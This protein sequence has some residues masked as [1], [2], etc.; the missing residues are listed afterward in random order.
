MSHSL[1]PSDMDKFAHL[2]SLI[3]RYK[4]GFV[5]DCVVRPI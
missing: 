3:I 4:I 1:A 5:A 2:A